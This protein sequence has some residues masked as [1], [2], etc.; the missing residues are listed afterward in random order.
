MT[1]PSLPV[2]VPAPVPDFVTAKLYTDVA[3]V[4]V[5][6]FAAVIVKAQAPV[7]EQAPDQLEKVDPLLAAAA[8]V[9]DLPDS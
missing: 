4:A 9:T 3:K 6:D 7:P 1:S 8:R 2:T 5:T